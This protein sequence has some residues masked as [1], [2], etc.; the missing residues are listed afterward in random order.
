MA[1]LGGSGL[2]AGL[3]RF[4]IDIPDMTA[5][6]AADKAKKAAEE[7]AEKAK[8][9]AGGAGSTDEKKDGEKK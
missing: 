8:K 7:A 4:G 9:L 1:L 6:E 2:M 3:K 5:G